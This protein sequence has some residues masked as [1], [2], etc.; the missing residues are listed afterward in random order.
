MWRVRQPQPVC[1]GVTSLQLEQC[2][3]SSDSQPPRPWLFPTALGQDAAQRFAGASQDTVSPKCAA[4][5]SLDSQKRTAETS[6]SQSRQVLWT[7]AGL[8][9]RMESAGQLPKVHKL[10]CP[11]GRQG[12]AVLGVL[13]GAVFVLEAASQ[14]LAC[15]AA[16]V[17]QAT[18]LQVHIWR[19]QTGSSCESAWHA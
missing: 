5:L 14:Q 18:L 16:G 7:G 17:P 8:L 2:V 12:K 15:S 3:E 9:V 4:Q 6:P 1:P 13:P 19:C 11:G 10:A